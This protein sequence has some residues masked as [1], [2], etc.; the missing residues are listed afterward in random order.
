VTPFKGT[1]GLMALYGAEPGKLMAGYCT[2]TQPTASATALLKG[3]RARKKREAAI[4]GVLRT[5]LGPDD[6][7][8]RIPYAT[9]KLRIDNTILSTRTDIGGVYQFNG[10]PAGTYQFAVKLPADFQVAAAKASRS[11]PSIT[12]TDQVCYAK[13]IYAAQTVPTG[14]P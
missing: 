5:E 3:L 2:Q 6:Y 11:L 1:A 7:N 4:V 9:V 13:D 14:S 12:I 8:H 10:V